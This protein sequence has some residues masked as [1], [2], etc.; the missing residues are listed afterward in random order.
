MFFIINT[1]DSGLTGGPF[2][3]PSSLSNPMVIRAYMKYFISPV[4][5][6]NFSR[7]GAKFLSLLTIQR[8]KKIIETT[9]YFTNYYS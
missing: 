9:K 4:G 2:R 7:G 3:L 5:E 6:K 8:Y 1:K